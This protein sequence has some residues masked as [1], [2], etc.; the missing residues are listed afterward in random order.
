MPGRKFVVRK[1]IIL[2]FNSIISGQVHFQK[3]TGHEHRS[4]N[5]DVQMQD[6]GLSL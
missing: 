3:Q 1:S 2:F 5:Y 4:R 6:I